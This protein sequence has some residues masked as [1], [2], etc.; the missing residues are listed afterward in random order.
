MIITQLIGGL[1]NQMFQYAAGRALSLRRNSRLLL[2]I[3][4]FKANQFHQGFE[5]RRVFC[6]PV[7]IA[8]AAEVDKLLGW[9]C[10]PLARRILSRRVFAALRRDALVVEP[11]F[12]YWP[13]MND[14][15]RDCYLAGYWQ[16]EK[17]FSD[18]KTEI[19]ADFTFRTPL[20][21][22]NKLL[23]EKIS[24]LNAVS[25][26]VR[27]GDYLTNVKSK[28][29]HGICSP[30]YYRAAI[31]HMA[32]VT[33][34]PYFF[35]FSDDMDWVRQHLQIDYECQYIEH[36]SGAESY[37]DMRLM[38]MCRHHIIA[39]S[40]FSWWGAWLNQ[41]I[42]KIVVAPQQWFMNDNITQDLYPQGWVKLK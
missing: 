12:H 42:D 20:Y 39:N 41:R 17:Y 25:L 23:A 22:Q 2:D 9:Q 3:S 26:H 11:H 30:E 32:E 10:S 33:E 28:S 38:S 31:R 40:S 35:V 24:Q 37:N 6:C 14:A 7:E 4:A 19:H 5:L 8:G 27:R 16:S 36:N 1:G 15:P 13:G 18:F 29:A 34:Q 21:G